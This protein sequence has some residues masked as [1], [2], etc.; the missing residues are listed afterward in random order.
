MNNTAIIT[1]ASGGIGQAV[2][3]RLAKRGLRLVLVARGKEKLEAL[4]GQLSETTKCDVF[5]LDLADQDAVNQA[6]PRLIKDFGKV[7]VLINNG[8][9]G[10]YKPFLES[11]Q[12]EINQLMQVHYFSPAQL[13]RA[14]LPGM[15][16]NGFGRIVNVASIAAQMGPWGHSGYGAAKAALLTLTESLACEYTQDDVRFS[17][18]SP[19]VIKTDF[20][21]KQEY[22]AMAKT[23]DKYGIAPDRVAKVIEKLIDRPKLSVIVPC[24]YRTLPVISAVSPALG[25]R[26]VKNGSKPK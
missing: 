21:N 25:H 9:A 26:A 12:N 7:S 13:I 5:P 6:A 11:D 20:F 22:S 15:L 10:M 17:V 19:G 18:V 16:E 14:A 23:V 24:W 1:G 2:A 3:Q 4:A 8:G